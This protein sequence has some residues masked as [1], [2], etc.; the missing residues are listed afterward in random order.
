MNNDLVTVATFT[1]LMEAELSKLRLESEGIIAFLA[2]VEAY[3]MDWLLGNAIGYIKL[4]V[5]SSQVEAAMAA[6][7]QMQS[8][9]GPHDE[10]DEEN[11]ADVCLSCGATMSADQTQCPECGWSYAGGDG[12]APVEP[13][14]QPTE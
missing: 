10:T 13:P 9:R 3:N 8:E 14:E 12:D 11:E 1:L 6:L 5:P 4:Q 2:D 7:E